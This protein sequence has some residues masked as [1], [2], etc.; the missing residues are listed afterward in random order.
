M[1]D[2]KRPCIPFACVLFFRMAIPQT[3]K[4]VKLILATLHNEAA[5]APT[6]ALQLTQA[7]GPIDFASA[8]FPFAATNYYFNEM[9]APL[10]RMFFSFE[11]LISPEDLATIK[12]RTNELEREFATNDKRTVNLDPGYLD[13]DKFVLA[14][15]KYHGYKIYLHDGIWADMTL[16]YEKGRF[17]AM[18]WSFP[19]FKSGAYEKVF[20]Q[21]RELYKKQ[22]KNF[23]PAQAEGQ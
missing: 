15:A 19:D 1:Q 17:L 13:A 9:G 8:L 5:P 11:R 22:I 3:V 14:S 20:I 21:I 2:R 18:P 4:P 10:T 7:F 6:F 12:R 16:H 23:A